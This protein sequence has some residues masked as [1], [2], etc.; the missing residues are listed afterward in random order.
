V[1]P[2]RSLSDIAF[3]VHEGGVRTPPLHPLPLP[4]RDPGAGR[5]VVKVAQDPTPLHFTSLHSTPVR[6]DDAPT[7]ATQRV[8]AR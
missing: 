8:G 7:G 1:V 4:K 2:I 3:R 6:G 5:I